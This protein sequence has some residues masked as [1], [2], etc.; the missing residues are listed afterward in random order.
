MWK[1]SRISSK[2]GA[3]LYSPC[4][5]R[6]ILDFHFLVLSPPLAMS[7]PCHP[8]YIHLLLVQSLISL[9][10]TSWF[11]G[12]EKFCP[13]RYALRFISVFVWVFIWFW[14]SVWVP[15]FDPWASFFICVC[16]LSL[17]L[18]AILPQKTIICWVVDYFSM[19]ARSKAFYFSHTTVIILF[20]Y[21]IRGKQQ[22]SLTFFCT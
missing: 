22:S 11:S 8:H 20:T 12:F 3:L 5:Y 10:I 21:L 1:V 15:D 2:H 13:C 16:S 19:T 9:S 17:M 14:I 18:P 4:S 7:Y 6:D